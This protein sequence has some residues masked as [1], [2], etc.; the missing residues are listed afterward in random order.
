VRAARIPPG[1]LKAPE[2]RAWPNKALGMGLPSSASGGISGGEG[3]QET[4]VEAEAWKGMARALESVV[5]SV[6]VSAPSPES[7]SAR[8]LGGEHPSIDK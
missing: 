2:G 6:S 4:K 8:L 1:A 3:F 5:S 7:S